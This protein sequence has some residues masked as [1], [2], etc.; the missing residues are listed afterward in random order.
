M[1]A[2]GFGMG[3]CCLQ[4]TFQ[5]CNVGEARRLYDA[6]VPLAPIFVRALSCCAGLALS[7]R[8]QLALTA[9]SPLYRGYVAD[10]DCRWNVIAASVDDRT[11]EERGL[12]VRGVRTRSRRGLIARG[13]R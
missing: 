11:P 6:M 9:A 2:M 4:L 7:V 10:V 3:C 5:C 13:S 12:K 1:D 8:A